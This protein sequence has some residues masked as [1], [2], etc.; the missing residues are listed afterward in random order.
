MALRQLTYEDGHDSH[1]LVSFTEAIV[2]GCAESVLAALKH[3]SASEW[4]VTPDA[5]GRTPIL[6]AC[7]YG[8]LAALE[9]LA[10]YDSSLLQQIDNDP[11]RGGHAI[12]YAC[13]GG[14]DHVIEWLLQ[15]GAT[16]DEKDLVG[17]SPLLYAVY[18]GNLNIV[19]QLLRRGRSLKETNN[20]GHSAVIQAACGGHQPLVEWLLANGASLHERD[21]VGNS[22]FLFA[23]WGGHLQLVNW[24]LHN[25]ASLEE[26]SDTGHTALLSAANSGAHN[27]V[28][29]LYELKDVSLTQRNS[30]GDTALL[31]AAFG[32]HCDLLLWLLNRGCSLDERNED[33][34]DALLSACNGGHLSMVSASFSADVALL[35][36]LH[37]PVVDR[38]PLTFPFRH[39]TPPFL[40]FAPCVTSRSNFCCPW[41]ARS[42][43]PTRAATAP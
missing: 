15:S 24:L 37:V 16:L 32:G 22:A 39:P 9:L 2:H 18:G 5:D 1:S 13:W 25:G 17:N 42:T 33:G 43:S 11:Q 20:K 4:V 29:W 23:A 3:P 28:K 6:L 36:A 35:A 30:N 38:I 12:H 40:P 8:S 7:R 19:Q 31:L 34:L 10:S 21:D 41:A 26:T 14:H 27:V